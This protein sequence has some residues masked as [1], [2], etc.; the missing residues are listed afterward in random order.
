MKL[1]KNKR[2]EK[3]LEK[4][5]EKSCDKLTNLVKTCEKEEETYWRKWMKERLMKKAERRMEYNKMREI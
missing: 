3:T 2:K 1:Q 5:K 4:K